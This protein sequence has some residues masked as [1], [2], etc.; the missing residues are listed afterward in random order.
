[1]ICG[2]I[3]KCQT[4]RAIGYDSRDKYHVFICDPAFPDEYV[5]LMIN[6]TNWGG[7]FGL[8]RSDYPF[9]TLDRCY[10]GCEEILSYE[11]EEL[12]N[13]LEDYFLGRLSDAHLYQLLNCVL[14]N[15]QMVRKN[16]TKING[17]IQGYL[18]AT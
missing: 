10:V 12:P 13:P 9:F 3:Y 6:K 1:M 14:K 11:I 18:A 17:A 4:D 15:G 16:K 7:D 5:F 8:L 2:E